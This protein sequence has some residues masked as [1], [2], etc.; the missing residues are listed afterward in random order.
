MAA[1]DIENLVRIFQ[2]SRKNPPGVGQGVGRTTGPPGLSRMQVGRLA[3]RLDQVVE[4][5]STR[6]FGGV[7]PAGNIDVILSRTTP[8]TASTARLLPQ[9]RQDVLP[10][11]LRGAALD[12]V[13]LAL[14]RAAD[15]DV[16]RARTLLRALFDPE[17]SRRLAVV[18]LAPGEIPKKIFD[19]VRRK[20]LD[21]LALIDPESKRRPGATRRIRRAPFPVFSEAAFQGLST[22]RLASVPGSPASPIETAGALVAAA[23]ARHTGTARRAARFSGQAIQAAD[24]FAI[25]NLSNVFNVPSKMLERSLRAPGGLFFLLSLPVGKVVGGKTLRVPSRRFQNLVRAGA[26]PNLLQAVETLESGARIEEEAL[27]RGATPEQAR[28]ARTARQQEAARTLEVAEEGEKVATG[29]QQRRAT[30]AG[31]A[32]VA[33]TGG[34]PVRLIADPDE[35]VAALLKSGRM[36]KLAAE[37]E[38]VR[39]F[40]QS[41]EAKALLARAGKSVPGI[42]FALAAL[43]LLM[44]LS[45]GLDTEVESAA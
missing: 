21:E 23:K 32:A 11:A 28:A 19:P 39:R 29:R 3:E 42:I 38:E 15:G 34:Q 35:D 20:M 37:S 24:R 2:R 26:F 4:A 12:D 40:L 18:G 1:E 36:R 25:A 16:N 5:I 13:A 9:L 7:A 14:L 43:P 22:A 41:K 45:S 27:A 8:I 33:G 30:K 31:L 17:T 6:R 10:R 44:A